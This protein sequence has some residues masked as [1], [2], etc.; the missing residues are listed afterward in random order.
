MVGSFKC[1][2][3]Q[4]TVQWP[5][6][7]FKECLNCA[8]C[9]PGRGLYPHKCGDTITF[10]AIIEGKKC[11]SGKTFSDAF[12]TSSCKLC[13]LCAEHEVLKKKCTTSSDTK[14]N[15]TCSSGYFFS[16]PQQ[17]CQMCSYCY[18]D[19]KDEKQP[20]CIDQELKAVHRYCTPRP[21][22]TSNLSTPTGSVISTESRSS[23]KHPNKPSSQQKHGKIKWTLSCM[24]IAL[25]SGLILFYCQ[26]RKIRKRTNRKDNAQNVSNL[27]EGC[28]EPSER[29]LSKFCFVSY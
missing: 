2:S 6:A 7:T 14:C 29:R 17:F 28:V 3:G 24:G 12:D 22:R 26:W 13:H 27:E 4:M 23:P 19:G 16:K 11:D 8:E 15:K 25:L 10:P 18:L 5:N 1:A 9:H 20:Q 21:D